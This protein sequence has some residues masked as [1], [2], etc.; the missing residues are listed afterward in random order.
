MIA[1]ILA[2][3]MFW[4][5]VGLGPWVCGGLTFLILIAKSI[6]GDEKPN[7]GNVAFAVVASLVVAVVVSVIV[8]VVFKPMHEKRFPHRYVPD[9]LLEYGPKPGSPNYRPQ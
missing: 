5:L 4:N 7:A 8:G 6:S 2:Q 1:E 3:N 9:E